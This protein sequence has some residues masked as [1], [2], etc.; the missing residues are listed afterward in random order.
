[1]LALAEAGGIDARLGS[2]VELGPGTLAAVSLAAS[3]SAVTSPCDLIGPL[4]YAEDVL[5]EP[6]E[7]VD[8][9]LSPREQPGFGIEL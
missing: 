4:V 1:M 8:G 3:S 9:A 5:T 2:T 6:I 7:Y